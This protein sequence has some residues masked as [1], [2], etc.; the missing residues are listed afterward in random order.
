MSQP[1]TAANP[2]APATALPLVPTQPGPSPTV[3]LHPEGSP[4]Y[5]KAW[6]WGVVGGVAGVVLITGIAVG[7]QRASGLPADI[8]YPTK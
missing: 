2:P 4:I 8:L 3:P 7:V 6:F 5:K 1:P